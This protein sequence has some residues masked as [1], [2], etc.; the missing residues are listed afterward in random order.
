[1]SSHHFVK[2]QQEP[3]LLIL[4]VSNISFETISPLLEWSPTVLVAESAI[5]AVLSWGIKIDIILASTEYQISHLALLEEQYPV[6]F[7]TVKED[8]FLEE[9][10]HYLIASKHG[11]VNVAGYDHA[12]VSELEPSIN[13]IDIV[14]IDGPIRYFPVKNG[15]FRK[16]YAGVS[17]QLHGPEG[18]LVEVKTEENSQIIKLTHATFVEVQGQVSIHS[19]ALFW[20]G[21]KM[22]EA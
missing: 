11:A 13:L 3:A 14:I 19:S 2:E 9:G 5:D 8:K 21:E 12:K 18:T 17:I 22:G 4:D 7:L 1:M 10:L 6:K 20:I 16:W 15:K